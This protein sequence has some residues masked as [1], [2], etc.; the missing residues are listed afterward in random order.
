MNKDLSILIDGCKNNDEKYQKIF[1]LKFYNLL[2]SHCRRFEL[3]STESK[4]V[5]HDAFITIFDS[6]HTL[7]KTD[8]RSVKAWIRT[9]TIRKILDKK[10]KSYIDPL[11]NSTELM[12]DWCIT[13]NDNY[14]DGFDFTMKDVKKAITKLPKR[15]K[16]IFKLFSIDGYSHKEISKILDITVGASKSSLHKSKKFI[17]RE[18]LKVNEY[19]L[20]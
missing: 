9:I 6:I 16:I 7:R 17:K 15:Y 19:E 4:D 5:I 2:L 1:Y 14:I 11:V 10:R 8:N 20:V 3:N 18:L 12:E 13:S